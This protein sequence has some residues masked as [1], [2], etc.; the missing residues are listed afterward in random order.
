VGDSPSIPTV[1]PPPTPTL[2]PT[3]A[4]GVLNTPAVVD[5]GTAEG[6]AARLPTFTAPAPEIR[7]TL[8]PAQGLQ[9]RSGLPPAVMISVLAVLGVFGG[10]ISLLRRR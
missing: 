3:S 7:P 4:L 10:L 5:G 9:G 6:S 1:V 8:L 2:P